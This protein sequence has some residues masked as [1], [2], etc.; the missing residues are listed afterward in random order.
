MNF[1]ETFDYKFVLNFNSYS[2]YTLNF[3]CMLALESRFT[4]QAL[5]VV[6]G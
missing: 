6:S 2:W 4:I 3:S 5:V 1:D